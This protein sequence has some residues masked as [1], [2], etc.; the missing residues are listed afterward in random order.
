MEDSVC[1]SDSYPF[2]AT[3]PLATLNSSELPASESIEAEEVTETL[4]NVSES[5]QQ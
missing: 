5:I 2:N 3:F 1:L 4:K